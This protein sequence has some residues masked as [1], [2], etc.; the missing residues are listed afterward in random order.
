MAMDKPRFVFAFGP[1]PDSYFVG[2]GEEME[3]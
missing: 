3:W 1:T 2:C